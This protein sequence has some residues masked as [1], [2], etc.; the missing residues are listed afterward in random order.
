[1]VLY[2]M[3]NTVPIM[4]GFLALMIVFVMLWMRASRKKDPVPVPSYPKRLNEDPQGKWIDDKNRYAELDPAGSR[5]N[6]SEKMKVL[7]TMCMGD[8]EKAE[9]L[10]RHE[11]EK[12]PSGGREKWIDEAIKRW[13]RDLHRL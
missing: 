3:K 8:R 5:A 6:D 2:L 10:I 4:G 13:G 1:M 9:R 12:Y 11:I 7:M